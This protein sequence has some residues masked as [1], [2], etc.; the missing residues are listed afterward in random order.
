MFH[1]LFSI[2]LGDVL[3]L[4]A[5]Y[6]SDRGIWWHLDLWDHPSWIEVGKVLDKYRVGK[7]T[8]SHS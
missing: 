4:Y 7:E 8:K 1:F 3:K 5:I 6:F 2:I